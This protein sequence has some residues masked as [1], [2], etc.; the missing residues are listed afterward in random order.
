[1]L[2]AAPGL[3]YS[4]RWESKDVKTSTEFSAARDLTVRLEPG[5]KREVKLF[6]RNAFAQETVETVAIERPGTRRGALDAAPGRPAPPPGMA[7]AAPPGGR[8]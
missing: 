3:G 2:S 6:V 4:Y 7:P 8:Q 5:E 1:V